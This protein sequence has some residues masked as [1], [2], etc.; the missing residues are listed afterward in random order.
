MESDRELARPGS[1][2]VMERPGT[3]TAT[4]HRPPLVNLDVHRSSMS[5]SIET[6]SNDK[7]DSLPYGGAL[8]AEQL[9]DYENI[10]ETFGEETLRC[11][12]DKNWSQREAGILGVTSN[13][14]ASVQS[15]ASGVDNDAAN[16]I[17][18]GSAN[19]L[20]VVSE[21]LDIALNDSVARVY[22]SALKLLQVRL[23]RSWDVS[24]VC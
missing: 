8:T 19:L 14:L 1:P 9:E 16:N 2:F 18:P 24:S 20:M 13:I 17:S 23:L 7:V 21:I 3:S 22:Q 15:P 6:N 5:V 12:L 4:K 10:V 11:L